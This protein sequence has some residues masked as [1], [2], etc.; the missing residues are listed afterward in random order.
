MN[1]EIKTD[2]GNI[3]SLISCADDYGFHRDVLFDAFREMLDDKLSEEEIEWYSRKLEAMDG[4]GEEDYLSCKK[5]LTNFKNK[6]C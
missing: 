4:F 2:L 5:R 1:R 3:L 6:Y